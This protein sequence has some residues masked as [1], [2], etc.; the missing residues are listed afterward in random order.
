MFC[1]KPPEHY[2]KHKFCIRSTGANACDAHA[3]TYVHS[4]QFSATRWQHKCGLMMIKIIIGCVCVLLVSVPKKG[5]FDLICGSDFFL[6]SSVCVCVLPFCLLHVNGCQLMPCNCP[7]INLYDTS[8]TDCFAD[9][10]T[11]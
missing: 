1:Q 5:V 9:R 2:Q 8:L 10:N 4:R 6:L 3:N 11:A 7:F